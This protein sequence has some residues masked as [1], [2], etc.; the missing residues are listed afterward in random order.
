MKK[1]LFLI[2]ALSISLGVRAQKVT[3]VKSST[4]TVN[5]NGKQLKAGDAFSLNSKI[6]WASPKQVI[7]V[8]NGNAKMTR[9]AA[10][11]SDNGKADLISHVLEKSVKHLSSRAADDL[12]GGD[13]ILADTLM[14][15]SQLEG[16]TEAK[17]ELVF[18]NQGKPEVRPLSLSSDK[19]FVIIKASDL[20]ELKAGS[21]TG[22]I[23]GIDGD[24]RFEITDLMNIMSIDEALKEE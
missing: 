10:T 16:D 1:Y 21:V 14:I 5:I 8:R 19:A 24:E 22:K 9:L 6:F 3:I 23:Y 11:L 18:E 20:P 12:P 13:F 15:P 2:I 17:V 7:I 4:P